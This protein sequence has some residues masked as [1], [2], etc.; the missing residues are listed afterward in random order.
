MKFQVARRARSQ[1][2]DI[3]WQIALEDPV[4][5]RRWLLSLNEILERIETYP[6]SGRVVPEFNRPELREAQHGDY[7]VLYFRGGSRLVVTCVI[8]GARMLNLGRDIQ[9]ALGDE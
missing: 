8:H 6:E 5:A 3:F 1:I 2:E 9:S 7:R 4:A